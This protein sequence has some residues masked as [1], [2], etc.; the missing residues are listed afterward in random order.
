MCREYFLFRLCFS[1]L[2][3]F[4]SL[5]EVEAQRLFR[6]MEWNVENLFDTLHDEH[7]RDVDFLPEGSYR[8]TSSRYWHKLSDVGR[9][10]LAVGGEAGFPALVGL[11]EVEN[12][13]VMRDLTRRSLLRNMR[14]DYVMTQS[15][16]ARGIDVALLYQSQVFRLLSWH[17]VRV[18]SLQHGFPPTRD[19]LYVKGL[20]PSRDTLHVVVCHLPSKAGGLRAAGQH[21]MLAVR[22]LRAVV[23]SVLSVTPRARMLVMGD[24]NAS[25]GE[26]VLRQLCPPLRETLPT[27][28]HALMRAIGTYYFQ[29]QWSYLDHILVS[30]GLYSWQD[31]LQNKLSA[32]EIRLPFLLNKEGAPHR[33]YRGDYY[34]GGISDHLPLCLDLYFW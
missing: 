20:V 24:Y 14:Y 10:I 13:S 21:R 16:D 3:T 18:P 29:Q 33:T 2:L 15:E 12:D 11:C 25:Y 8:W 19:I 31:S 7:K 22:T 1:I 4:L 27:S 28:R 26:K 32:H 34:N 6:V 23:D 9:T 30:E 17:A 5:S